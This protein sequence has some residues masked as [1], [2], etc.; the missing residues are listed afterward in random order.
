[1]NGPTVLLLVLVI[2]SILFGILVRADRWLDASRDRRNRDESKAYARARAAVARQQATSHTRIGH[3][4]RT[5][6]GEHHE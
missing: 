2:A 1:V 5:D 4:E 6:K 3:T